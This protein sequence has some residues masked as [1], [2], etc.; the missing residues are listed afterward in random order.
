[1]KKFSLNLFAYMFI[2][3]FTSLNLLASE[4]KTI[5]I[6]TETVQCSMCKKTIEKALDKVDGVISADVDYRKKITTVEYN[7]NKT[8]PQKIKKAIA[9]AGYDAGEV[10]ADKEGYNKLPKCCKLPEDRK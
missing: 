10:K 2:L 1:M 9:K 7:S 5:E 4:T 8:N 3:V 6:D